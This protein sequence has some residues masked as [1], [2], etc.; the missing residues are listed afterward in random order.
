MTALETK[1]LNAAHNGN[2]QA[3]R[4]IINSLTKSQIVAFNPQ[5]FSTILSD[6][7]TF[8]NPDAASQTVRVF[9][10]KLG[11]YT[12]PSAIAFS[13]ADFAHNGN[14]K[15]VDAVTD[16]LTP[17]QKE[18]VGI[19]LQAQQALHDLT[20]IP[21]ADAASSSV[22]D[23]MSK[24][25]AYIDPSAIA[26]SLADFAH[27]GNVKGVDAVTDYLTPEQK[28]LVGIT[29]QAQQ[30]LH[31]LTWIPNADAA[32]S[33]VRD[34]MSKIGA[35]MDPTAVHDS[36][37]DF[38]HNGNDAGV[39]GMLDVIK[40][41]QFADLPSSTRQELAD[42][43]YKLGSY[44]VDTLNGSSGSDKLFG[45]GGNDVLD[46]KG[47]NDVLAGGAGND[48]LKGGDGN[49]T[50]YGGI[51]TDT[52]WGGN[53]RDTFVFDSVGTGVD[54]IQDFSKT[55]GDKLDLHLILQGFDPLS[56]SISDF[57][58][59]TKQGTNST[60]I[61]V[62]IDGKGGSA[63]F[64]DVAILNGVTDISINDLLAKGQI[65]A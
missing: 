19:T 17:E 45:L 52:L 8:P 7:T 40:Q 31:D 39:A 35:Y 28:E 23:L 26:H 18:L 33:S 37:V 15:G 58:H 61:S 47:G 57:I 5:S 16:Y 48:T 6:I 10:Q 65:I 2:M 29:P 55:Q 32:S 63:H 21:N 20:W 44:G 59:A 64:V 14:V 30:A 1:L 13:L 42:L 9:A 53:G 24:I 46:G 4:D 62:D 38:G 49:D 50:L 51:G 11:S 41:A 54:T 36:L 34:L 43:G 12:D 27:N 56:D 3:V 25:G 22:R 60:M